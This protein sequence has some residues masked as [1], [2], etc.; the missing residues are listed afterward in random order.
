MT[1]SGGVVDG[2]VE[3]QHQFCRRFGGVAMNGVCG[4]SYSVSCGEKQFGEA[5]WISWCVSHKGLD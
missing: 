3:N 2:P 4:F 1:G 5:P